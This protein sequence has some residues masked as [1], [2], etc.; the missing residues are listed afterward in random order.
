MKCSKIDDIGRETVELARANTRFSWGAIALNAISI[1]LSGFAVDVEDKSALKT[2]RMDDNWLAAVAGLPSI[3]RRGL[4]FL[5]AALVSKGWV[6]VAEA[7]KFVEIEKEH[8]QD[9]EQASFS[10]SAPENRGAIM[11]L[12]RAES[13]LPGTLARVA[14]NTKDIAAAALGVLNFTKEVAVFSGK[15]LGIIAAWAKNMRS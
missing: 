4:E 6:S 11:L 2:S 1:P 13:E 15:S 14:E 10:Q 7:L 8:R 9:A 12:A 5:S 3:S